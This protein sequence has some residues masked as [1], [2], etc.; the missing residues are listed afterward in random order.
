MT[1]DG[2]LHKHRWDLESIP[3]MGSLGQQQQQQ[4][5]QQ[6]P[7]VSTTY[8]SYQTTNQ[9]YQPSPI[10]DIHNQYTANGES[11]KRKSRFA[12]ETNWS[13]SKQAEYNPSPS[14]QHNKK[15]KGA[16]I[17]GPGSGPGPSPKGETGIYGP[18]APTS[19]S[20]K[21]RED[22]LS[23]Q[24][25]ATRFSKQSP[26]GSHAEDSI[27]NSKYGPGGKAG[28]KK[29]KGHPQ[30]TMKAAPVAQTPVV[31]LTEADLEKMKVI[32][33]CQAF[34]KDYFRLTSAPDPSTVR[35][36]HVLRRALDFV[37][38]KWEL[39]KHSNKEIKSYVLS[40]FKS[41]RQDLTL[42]HISNGNI[43]SA[44]P[45]YPLP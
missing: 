12:L 44:C 5:Q 28:Q 19:A 7:S 2:R 17:Y 34:E 9:G 16:G 35:P 45:C 31:P 8:S 11:K 43:F 39:E 22:A 4:Q 30:Q 33:T 3:R 14:P 18:G 42:Q 25:R 13:S 41:L 15:A 1:V 27:G 29:K 40:Q 38:Q 24:S 21:E 37:K 26:K 10:R 36:Q 6:P 23:R 32:G 20:N